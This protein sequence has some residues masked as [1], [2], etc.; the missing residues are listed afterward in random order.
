MRVPVTKTVRGKVLVSPPAPYVS[1]D[2]A[3]CGTRPR[4]L[5]KKTGENFWYKIFC[6]T[7][8]LTGCAGLTPAGKDNA[9]LSCFYWG[10]SC[11]LM[12]AS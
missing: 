12:A 3:F 7:A 4:R 9:S 1:K 11:Q 10:S 2:F 6:E 8:F 5:L